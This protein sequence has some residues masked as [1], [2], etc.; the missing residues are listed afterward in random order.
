MSW[1]S[2]L[3]NEGVKH[4]CLVGWRARVSRRLVSGAAILIHSL[5]ERGWEA[6]SFVSSAKHPP[7]TQTFCR[8]YLDMT[9]SSLP[10]SK[11]SGTCLHF[12]ARA[13]AEEGRSLLVNTAFPLTS[14][15]SSPPPPPFSPFPDCFCRILFYTAKPSSV[16]SILHSMDIFKA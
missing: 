13:D 15:T 16:L 5:S 10:S 14:S 9:I 11:P 4:L 3:A 2:W 7:L 8:E 6:G 1:R 12:D